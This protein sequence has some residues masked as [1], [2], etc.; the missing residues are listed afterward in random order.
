VTSVYTSN[1]HI[2]SAVAP[3]PHGTLVAGLYGTICPTGEASWPMMAS[4]LQWHGLSSQYVADT[5]DGIVAA[6]KRGHPVLLGNMLT[7]AGHIVLVIGYTA[8]GNLIVNDPYGDKF[9]PGYGSN[10]GDGV[11][12]PWKRLTPRHALEVIGT[13]PPPPPTAP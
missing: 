4:V 5:W 9:A 12:Y 2:Y 6:L 3:D 11:I 7:S 13:Y 10:N 8:D 1:G